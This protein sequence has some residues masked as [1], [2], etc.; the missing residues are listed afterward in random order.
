VDLGTASASTVRVLSG[1]AD[2]ATCDAIRSAIASRREYG[3]DHSLSF[4]RSGNRYFVPITP[5]SP[6]DRIR[7]GEHSVVEVYDHRFQ[8]IER[9]SA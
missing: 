6:A 2:R 8:L 4:F 3:A 5:P 1:E 7:I 9:I